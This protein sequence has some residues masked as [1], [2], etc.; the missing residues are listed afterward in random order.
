[1]G[2]S[3]VS[4]TARQNL[5]LALAG[6]S[7]FDE[8]RALETEAL[9]I[10]AAQGDV[11]MEVN[12]RI[13]LSLVSCLAG[14][15]AG[16]EREALAA[17]EAARATPALRSHA[18]AALARALLDLGRASDALSAASEAMQ[19]LETLGGIE[20]GESLVRLAY[21][22]ALDAVGRRAE[23]LAAFVA[24]A[25]RLQ[26]RAAKMSDPAWRKGFLERVPENAR[27]IARARG[28]EPA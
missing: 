4:A 23:A 26:E 12:T 16:A 22:E 2:L 7:R 21:A 9:E 3:S 18:L 20:E 25:E 17:I 15:A 11:R 6:Q 28:H 27:T 14:D 19:L 5:G 24:G 1:M 8:A 13:A 10:F